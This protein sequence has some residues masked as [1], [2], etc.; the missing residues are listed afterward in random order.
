[1][2]KTC[3]NFVQNT[4]WRGFESIQTHCQGPIVDAVLASGR[5]NSTAKC[6]LVYSWRSTRYWGAAHGLAGILHILMH[7]PLSKRDGED[8]KATLRYMIKGRY[9][10]G[11]Y[12][13]S[14][15]NS[16]GD[17]LVHWCHGAP[18]VAITLCKAVQVSHS[19]HINSWLLFPTQPTLISQDT[20]HASTTR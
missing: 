4:H 20:N 9:L 11:N 10:R 5:A 18:G 17:R 12:R 3:K 2:P 15:G 16:R 19:C 1:M 13:A 14:E 8:I 6:P 7:F